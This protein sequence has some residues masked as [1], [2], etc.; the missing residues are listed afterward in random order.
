MNGAVGGPISA[1]PLIAAAAAAVDALSP[2][3]GK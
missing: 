2:Q 3:S 1:E